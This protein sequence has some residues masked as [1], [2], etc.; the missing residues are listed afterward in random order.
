[1]NATVRSE[2]TKFRS[3]RSLPWLTVTA[4]LAAALMALLF[5]VSL[6]LT[7][8]RGVDA[9]PAAEVVRA[10]LVGIDVAAIVLMV[11]GASVAGSEYSS[12]L[13]QPT[14]L[15]TPR[16]GRVVA[17]KALV[18]G[19]VA[20]GASAAAAVLCTLTGQLVLLG[21]GLQAAPFDAPLA[22]L[23]AGSALAPVFY[24]LVALAAALVL[25]STGGG[26]VVALAVLLLPVLTGWVPGL[27]VVAPLLPAAAVH[28]LAGVSVPGTAE[29]LAP[30]TAAVSLVGWIMLLGGVS[31][32]RVRSRDA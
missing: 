26:V 21:A 18:V 24:A 15:L 25:R 23:A 7:Q 13:A 28:G 30:V 31:L 14:F 1:M 8:G 32:W 4:V 27:D 2:W 20:L 12:G 29:Y 10:A 6:P 3:V 9:M 17:A 16:R 19:L 11:M 22:R 5:V